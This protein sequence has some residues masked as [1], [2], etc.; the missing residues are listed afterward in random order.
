MR[1]F[2]YRTAKIYTDEYNDEKLQKT[3]N[4]WGKE[5]WEVLSVIVPQPSNWTT[6]VATAKREII[7]QRT[8]PTGRKFR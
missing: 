1:F 3:L 7:A 5:G 8:P 6:F 4:E 2:E